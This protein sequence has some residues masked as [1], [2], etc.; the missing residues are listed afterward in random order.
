M[1]AAQKDQNAGRHRG[2]RFLVACLAITVGAAMVPGGGAVAANQ[3]TSPSPKLITITIPSHGDVPSQWLRYSGPPHA[4]VLLPA[5]YNPHKRYPLLV[6]LNGLQTDYAWW[7]E[8]GFMPLFNRLDA[9]V[10]MPEGA[11]GWYTNWWNNGRRGSPAWES[12]DLDVVLP[13]ILSRYPIL[14]QRRYHAVAGTSMGGGGAVYLAGRLPGFFGSVAS[15]SGWVDPQDSAPTD[16]ALMATFAE[17]SLEGDHNP[18][19]VDGPPYDFYADGHNPT[20]LAMNLRQT[21]VFVSTG[22]GIPN[23][24][25]A[26]PADPIGDAEETIIYAMNK[27]YHPS[28]KAGGV[29]VTYQVHPGG[30]DIPAFMSEVKA[31]LAWGLFKPVVT[32]PTSWVNHTVATTGRLWDIGYRFSQPP[33]RVVQFRRVGSS[34]SINP[35]GSRV[36]LTTSGGCVIRTATPATVE[37]PTHCVGSDQE[38]ATAQYL[39]T[40][41]RH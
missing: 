38:D 6:L 1:T 11:N 5:G 37:L 25:A 17:A 8:A 21:R 26:A 16:Q 36:T 15:L 18:D 3:S 9:I 10:V 24:T 33:D 28:L 12:Y 7:A 14:P 20:R 31:M 19:P 41:P 29:D 34:L 30:H 13:A 40:L 27:L 39:D 35:T 23:N 2:S 32:D 4:N 22:T